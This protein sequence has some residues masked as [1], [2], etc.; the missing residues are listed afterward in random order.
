[1]NAETLAIKT[2]KKMRFMFV[3][4]LK[5]KS[6]MKQ[7]L[8][9]NKEADRWY[10]DL[11]DWTGTKGELE[12]VAGAD[13]LLDFLDLDKDNVVNLT[14]ST[15]KFQG[16][17]IK[18][19]KLLNCFGGTTYLTRSS[20]FNKPVWLCAVTKYVFDGQLPKRIYVKT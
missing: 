19:S 20:N 13:T 2:I 11:P 9:F 16:A 8:K 17:S 6:I 18:L 3:G 5:K 4:I 12:M 7:N 14:V 1:M 10:I 15:K